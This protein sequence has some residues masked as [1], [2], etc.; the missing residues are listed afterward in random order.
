MKA[1]LE[2]AQNRSIENHGKKNW[3]VAHVGYVMEMML[4]REGR[5]QVYPL[6]ITVALL[7]VKGSFTRSVC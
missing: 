1:V 6:V 3:K 4:P 5:T 7:D 2:E